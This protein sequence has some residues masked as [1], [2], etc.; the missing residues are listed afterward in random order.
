MGYE[1]PHLKDHIFQIAIK[2]FL[3]AYTFSV[4]Q[5]MKCCVGIIVPDGRIIPFVPTTRWDTGNRSASN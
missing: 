5:V 4:K 1:L 2:D 3:D